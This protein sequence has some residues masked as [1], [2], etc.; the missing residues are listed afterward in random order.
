MRGMA[1][2]SMTVTGGVDDRGQE[3]PSRHYSNKLNCSVAGLGARKCAVESENL[4]A[5]SPSFSQ[6]ISKRRPIIQA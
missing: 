3:P 2:K 4:Q 6:A 5:L 1:L